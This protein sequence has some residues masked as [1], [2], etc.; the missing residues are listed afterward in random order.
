VEDVQWLPA[1]KGI[2]NFLRFTATP[3]ETTNFSVVVT[4]AAGCTA[5]DMVRIILEPSIF[6]PNIFSPTSSNGNERFTLFSKDNLPVN[7]LRIYDRWG[8]LVFENRGFLTNDLASGWDGSFRGSPLTPSVF[9]F[10]AE[11]EYEPGL[12]VRLQGDITL[13][14]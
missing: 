8:E 12:L 7:W 4:D 14:R 2:P 9:V 5:T 13:L 10:M 11:V 1:G 6:A 3:T